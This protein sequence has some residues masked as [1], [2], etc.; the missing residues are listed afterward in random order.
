MKRR[1]FFVFLVA[2]IGWGLSSCARDITLNRETVLFEIQK[3]DTL[4]RIAK[5]LADNRI[6]RDPVRFKVRAKIQG[7]DK[8]LQV[9]TYQILPGENLDDLIKK[10]G[11]GQ[12]YARRMTILEGWNIY[13]IASYLV[14]QNFI[15]NEKEF[16]KACERIDLVEELGVK[17]IKNLEGFLFPDTYS[18]PLGLT[19]EDIVV[20]MVKQFKRVVTPEMRQALIAHGLSFYQALTL[21]SIVEKETSVEYEK[22]IVAGVFYNRLRVRM[23]LQTDPTLIY[24]RQ[25]EGNWDGN[26]RKRDFTN[27][28]PYNTYRYYGLPPGP[29]ANPGKSALLAVAYPAQTEYLYFVA[30]ND[31]THYFSSTLQEHNRAVQLYQLRRK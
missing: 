17:G 6:I 13:D 25:M 14:R 27:T 15:S 18:V 22:P 12:V 8:K 2:I 30:K 20:L 10:M 9:G 11:T 23:K 1:V 21:A 24:I 26:I 16:F 19:A 7:Y 4:N 29:I 5:R 3:G 31:G 28:S